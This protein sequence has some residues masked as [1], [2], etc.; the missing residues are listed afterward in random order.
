ME[1][2][3]SLR[4]CREKPWQITKNFHYCH[5]Q[6]GIPKSAR[7][8]KA[9]TRKLND[10]LHC[11]YDISDYHVF[12]LEFGSWGEEGIA[13]EPSAKLG[14]LVSPRTVRAYWPQDRGPRGG[15]RNSTQHWRAFVRNHAR[16]IVAADFLVAITAGFRLL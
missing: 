1:E 2:G 14:I 15:R 4:P 9:I 10:L 11:A 6:L 7:L 16:A 13:A 8:C 12:D 5:R 3:D